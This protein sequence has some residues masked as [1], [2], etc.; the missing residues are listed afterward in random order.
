MSTSIESFKAVPDM[1]QYDLQELHDVCQKRPGESATVRA[2]LEKK[3][4]DTLKTY[5]NDNIL[6][7]WR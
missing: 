3:W 2:F 5:V 7:R 4:L 1:L 6:T